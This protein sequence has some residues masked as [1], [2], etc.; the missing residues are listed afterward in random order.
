MFKSA[1]ILYYRLVNKWRVHFTIYA[2]SFLI[3]KL[4]S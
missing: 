1:S 4:Y 3:R 2:E